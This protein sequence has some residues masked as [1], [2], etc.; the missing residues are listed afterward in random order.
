MTSKRKSPY[1]ALS[2]QQEDRR[3][4]R[5]FT[6]ELSNQ[7]LPCVP[8]AKGSWSAQKKS[9]VLSHMALRRRRR[10]L[11]PRAAINDLHPFQGCPF[12]Q[13]GYF[14]TNCSN[15][16]SLW[17]C[18]PLLS[19]TAIMI[20][21]DSFVSCKYFFQVSKCVIC[22]IY[23][24]STGR[25]Q[26]RRF[27]FALLRAVCCCV[28]CNTTIFSL[29]IHSQRNKSRRGCMMHPRL[30]LFPVCPGIRRNHWH[31]WHAAEITL[32]AF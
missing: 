27:Q 5:S 14:S 11:N 25:L 16:N 31:H 4:E 9:H 1:I 3:A 22:V 17:C 28:D 10:D 21:A 29:T 19:A 8:D 13:L 18:A 30:S 26:L 20:I 32:T 23:E 7:E 15:H 24:L 2:E 12:G 6:R